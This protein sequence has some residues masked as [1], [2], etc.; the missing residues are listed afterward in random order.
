M[1]NER[2]TK[3]LVI[4]SPLERS[5]LINPDSIDPWIHDRLLA[6]PQ[7]TVRIRFDPTFYN[8]RVFN[9]DLADSLPKEHTI[10][11]P[12]VV[13]EPIKIQEE[14][15]T[16]TIFQ[17]VAEIL[18]LTG[19]SGKVIKS[20]LS[21][22]TGKALQKLITATIDDPLLDSEWF[23]TYAGEKRVKKV[24]FN[25]HKSY[26]KKRLTE[27][28]GVLH[29]NKHRKTKGVEMGFWISGVI[30]GSEAISEST[31]SAGISELP[32]PLSLP[33][34]QDPLVITSGDVEGSGLIVED[35]DSYKLATENPPSSEGKAHIQEVIDHEKPLGEEREHNGLSE[36]IVKAK[37][38][39]MRIPGTL[40]KALAYELCIKASR[41]DPVTLEALREAINKNRDQ[42]I[43]PLDPIQMKNTIQAELKGSYGQIRTNPDGSFWLQGVS[44]QPVYKEEKR[45]AFYEESMPRLRDDDAVGTTSVVVVTE[46]QENLDLIS[47]SLPEENGVIAG[48]LT[49]QKMVIVPLPFVEEN[50]TVTLSESPTYTTEENLLLSSLETNR[51]QMINL[52]NRYLHNLDDS[53]QMVQEAWLKIWTKRHTY[54]PQ[55]ST[56]AAWSFTVLR[57]AVID[58]IRR[59]NRRPQEIDLG[60]VVESTFFNGYTPDESSVVEYDETNQEI[61]DTLSSLPPQYKT[62]L[63]LRYFEEFSYD[64]IAEKLGVPI[65][66]VRMRLWRARQMLRKSEKAQNLYNP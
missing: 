30:V 32:Q 20:L 16:S 18:V 51:R 14:A 62:I 66:T 55:G 23:N 58:E 17:D 3:K 49:S 15:Q 60:N 6:I 29:K 35:N 64:Q 10:S 41:K 26:I 40:P 38:R 5:S 39:T 1:S 53:E 65:S 34:D 8:E 12:E 54:K 52:A 42:S 45:H 61:R 9:K 33:D 37:G 2:Y 46:N 28:G 36:V 31:S 43:E 47:D 25:L 44:I 24:A 21:A 22:G 50:D 56:H 59:L 48:E 11:T 7:R 19:E 57:N 13:E 63:E 4:P 27:I